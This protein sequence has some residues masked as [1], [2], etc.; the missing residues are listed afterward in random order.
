MLEKTC[1]KCNIP[2]LI[3]EYYKHSEMADGYLNKCKQC[4]KKDNKDR[5][6]NLGKNQNWADKEKER[7]RDKY[8]RLNYLNKHK[9]TPE[10]K[11]EII[12][13]YKERY[14]EKYTAKIISSKIKV[15]IKSN[16]MHHWNYN[17][18]HAMDVIELTPKDHAKIHRFIKYDQETFMYRDLSGNILDTKIKHEN[19]IQGLLRNVICLPF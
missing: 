6:E 1:F 16:E 11:A 3:S 7:H 10:K 13:R 17:L 4:A 5:Q 15:T 14:P 2:K 9:P 8:H 19:Y 12:A 18:K